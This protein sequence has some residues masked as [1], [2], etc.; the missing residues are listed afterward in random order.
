VDPGG[1]YKL[2]VIRDSHAECRIK[3]IRLLEGFVVEELELERNHLAALVSRREKTKPNP[4]QRARRH[5]L[6]RRR[7]SPDI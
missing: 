4:A 1:V 6:M 2:Q 3:D 7:S 5:A